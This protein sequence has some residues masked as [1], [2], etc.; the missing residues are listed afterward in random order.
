MECRNINKTDVPQTKVS[1]LPPQ[2]SCVPKAPVFCFFFFFF[3]I[4]Y[5]RNMITET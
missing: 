1:I 3:G 2:K 4:I 5:T